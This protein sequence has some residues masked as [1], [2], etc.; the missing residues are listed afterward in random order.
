MIEFKKK[1]NLNKLILLKDISYKKWFI[2]LKNAVAGF[3]LYKTINV[4]H[5]LMGGTSQKLNNYIFAGIPSFI[6]NNNDFIKFNNKFETSI[7]VQI[8][9]I[10]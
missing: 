2:L 8:L 3:A 4:S 9:W 6:N 1:N 10:I 7:I 5:N